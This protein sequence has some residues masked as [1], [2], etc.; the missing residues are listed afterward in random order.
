[1]TRKILFVLF[2]DDECRQ[3]HALWYTLD[4]HRQGHEVR[5]LLEGAGAQLVQQLEVP[6]SGRGDLLRK[7]QSAGLLVGACHAASIGC[8]QPGL[9]SPAV[10]T[11]TA[12]GIPLREDMDGHAGLSTFVQQGY[13][14]VV[15]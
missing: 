14:L 6:G 13:E 8:G 4:L 9:D 15:I 10:R 2:A 7:V 5:L 1:M 11:A 12:Y 3:S